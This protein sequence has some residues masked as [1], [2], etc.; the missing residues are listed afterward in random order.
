MRNRVIK[1]VSGGQTGADRAALDFALE[2]G[3]ATNG[4][5][6]KGRVAEDGEIS[7][8]Y[9][10]LIET[11]SPDPEERTRL[12]VRSADATLILSHG[13]LSGGSK[14]AESF[15]IEHNKPVLHVD[16]LK[17]PL[18]DAVET[19]LKWI[20]STDCRVLNIAGPRLSEDAEIY[21]AVKNFLRL[22]WADE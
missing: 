15:A 4:Y 20:D 12:N 10:N 5:V 22:L 16:F 1:I 11:V 14:L 19:S 6:P 13:N 21:E 2:N 3:I 17:Q 8:K 18:D 9:P 7:P